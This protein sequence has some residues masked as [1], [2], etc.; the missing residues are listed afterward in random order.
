MGSRVEIDDLFQSGCLGLLK[1]C[2][3]FDPNRGTKLLT[4]AHN[5]IEGEI[6]REIEKSNKQNVESRIATQPT[7]TH[8]PMW[9]VKSRVF[10]DYETQ[11]ANEIY[12]AQSI[13]N[14]HNIQPEPLEHKERVRLVK[15]FIETLP[16][17]LKHVYN[18][19]FVMELKQ[20]QMAEDLGI[21]SERVR[22]LKNRILALGHVH[23]EAL[24]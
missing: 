14:W 16:D 2:N 24:M 5:Y 3:R 7:E 19:L 13:S 6:R 4:F 15:S 20:K 10:S 22:Q 11:R 23:F 17:R 8:E 9:D 18:G 21:S 1:A 12:L